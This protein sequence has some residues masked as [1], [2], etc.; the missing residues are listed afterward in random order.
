[1]LT[2]LAYTAKKMDPDQADPLGEV[3][4]GFILFAAM[5]KAVWS[6]FEYM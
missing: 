3:W 6:A 4:S 1:M 5:I 2:L